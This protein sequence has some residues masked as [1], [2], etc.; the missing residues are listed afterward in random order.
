MKRIISIKD[1]DIERYGEEYIDIERIEAV[2][3]DRPLNSKTGYRINVTTHSSDKIR[4]FFFKTESKRDEAYTKVI[5]AWI[6]ND[7][8]KINIE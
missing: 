3:I 4:S 2:R 7:G 1:E 6:G 5:E 8:E